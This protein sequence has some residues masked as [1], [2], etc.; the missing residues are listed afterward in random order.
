[1]LRIEAQTPIA[2][3]VHEVSAF[4]ADFTHLPRWNYCVR[5]VT[6]VTPGSLGVVA[7]VDQ[8]RRAHRQR[9]FITA[10]V[11][12]RP[13]S[14]RFRVEAGA[15]GAEVIET[16]DLDMG[17]PGPL[18]RLAHSRIQA[19]VSVNHG[20]LATLLETGE[21]R[22]VTCSPSLQGRGFSVHPRWYPHESP[23][24]LPGP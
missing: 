7:V 18:E 1:M 14:L 17:L 12:A 22:L 16:W 6:Q 3:T 23:K 4:L 2:R 13:L 5:T 20:V 8:V 19:A 21:A 9:H 15:Q 11:P 10:F 24:G